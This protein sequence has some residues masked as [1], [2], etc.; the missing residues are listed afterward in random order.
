M[1]LDFQYPD[2]LWE[3]VED[4]RIIEYRKDERIFPWGEV[5]RQLEEKGMLKV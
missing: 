2:E 3:D 1:L 4:C 5:K